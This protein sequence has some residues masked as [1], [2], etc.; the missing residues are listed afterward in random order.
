[1]GNH[2]IVCYVGN[3]G[4]K[5]S[6]DIVNFDPSENQDFVVFDVSAVDVPVGQN[7]ICDECC[8]RGYSVRHRLVSSVVIVGHL[9]CS[10]G[11]HD[12]GERECSG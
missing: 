11:H 3:I 7:K 9:P 4:D 1:M 12:G 8:S 2:N 6:C 10:V 5:G